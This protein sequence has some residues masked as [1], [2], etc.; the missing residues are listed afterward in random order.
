M[1]TPQGPFPPMQPGQ[2]PT[3]EQIRQMQQQIAVEAQKAGVSVPEYVQRLKAAAMQKHQAQMALRAQQQQQGGGAPPQQQLQQQQQQQQNGAQ[4]GQQVPIQPGPPKPEALA[5][6]H[7]LQGQSLKTRT[8]IFQDKRKDMFKGLS[9]DH[10]TS[11]PHSNI[12]QSNA[13][14]EHSSLPRTKKRER[15]TSS[16]L[17]SP[18]VL[19]PRI[20]SSCSRSPS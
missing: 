9:R 6:A 2:Q 4:P 11:L 5:V 19:L 15:R 12:D 14:S 8:C 1:A 3:P 13:R 7:F 20:P 10:G 17:P 18:T 16:Y